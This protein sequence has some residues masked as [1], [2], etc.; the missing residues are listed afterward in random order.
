MTTTE[1]ECVANV[2]PYSRTRMTHPGAYSLEY[3][4]MKQI[5]IGICL[6]WDY[7]NQRPKGKGILGTMYVLAMG[8][9]EQGCRTPHSHY[10][11]YV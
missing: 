7:K 9:E 2:T 11:V 3:Q 1:D 4:N 6:Q 10:Q 5:V 8:D